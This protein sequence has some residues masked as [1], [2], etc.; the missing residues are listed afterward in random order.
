MKD[1]DLEFIKENHKWR[2]LWTDIFDRYFILIA[3]LFFIF[4]SLMISYFSIKPNTDFSFLLVAIPIFLFGFLTFYLILKRLESERQF[5]I[6]PFESEGSEFEDCFINLGWTISTQTD[7]VIIGETK[8]SW[9]SWGESITIV[10]ANKQLL[11][12]SRPR[13]RQPFTLNRDKVN[14]KKLCDAIM[15]KAALV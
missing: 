5:K 12:N 15:K 13:G 14:Y 11:F 7:K 3:P 8:T 10:F 9:F 6:I 1:E 2:F 4:L